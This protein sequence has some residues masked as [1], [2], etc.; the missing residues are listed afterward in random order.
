MKAAS[1]IHERLRAFRTRS[2]EYCCL[3]HDRVGAARFVVETASALRG[4][5]LDVG[6]GK[7]LLAI[8]LA[9]TGMEVVSVDTDGEEQELAKLLAEQAGVGT[10]V[11]FVRGDAAHLSYPD[12]TFGCVAM[13][14]VL[15]HLD[16][17][18]PVL[19]EMVRVL[20]EAGLIVVADFDEQGFDL[21]SRVHCEEGR[22]H[23]RTAATVTC[24]HDELFRAGLRRATRTTG[25]LHDV[26]VLLK[27]H[28]AAQESETTVRAIHE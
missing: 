6:T 14:D 21:V 4:P 27:K 12:A 9:R 28:G 24:A 2:L 23:P 10:R 8:E 7:G 15:H 20:E 1:D 22:D 5:A 11:S 25:C 13:M 26:V 3:G 19:R 18:G 17:P 16:K